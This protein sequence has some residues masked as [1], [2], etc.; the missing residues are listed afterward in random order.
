MKRFVAPVVLSALAFAPDA[1]AQTAKPTPAVQ[2]VVVVGQTQQ[3]QNRIDRTVYAVSRD[4]QATSG[5]AA[6]ILNN[7]PSVAVDPD[8]GL[9]LRGDSNVTVLVDGKPSAQFTGAAKGLSLQQ[10]PASQIERVEVLANPPAQ[11]KAE[12]SGGV[13]NIITKKT[14]KTGLSGSGQLTLGDKRRFV[15]ALEGAY[16]K[17]R[18]KLSGGIGLRQDSRQRLSTDDRVAVDP[19]TGV[20]TPSRQII[21]ERFRRLVP[22]IKAGVDYDLDAGQALGGSFSHREL[23]GVRFFDQND[24]VGPA[25]PTA[26]S[27]RHS[28]GHDWSSDESRALHFEQKLGRPGE[29]LSIGLQSS[30]SREQERYL[31]RNTFAVPSGPATFD[32]LHLAFAIRKD[33]FSADYVLP[34]ASGREL[35]LGYDLEDDHNDFD[36]N[37]NALTGPGGT[38]SRNTADNHF[39]YRQRINAVYGQYQA[40]LG[41]WRLQAGLRV[42]Q[43]DVAM[44][45]LV[46]HIPGGRRDVGVYPSLHLDRDIGDTAKLSASLS[47]RISRPDPEALNPFIDQ[48]NTHNLRAGNPNLLPQDTWSYQLGYSD[49]RGDLS[50]GATGYLR[51]DRNTVTDIVRPIGPDVVLATRA[52]LPNTRAGGIEFNLNGKIGPKLGYGLSGNLFLSQIDASGLGLRG[53]KS[54][55][56]LNLKASLDYRPTAA[57]SAQI[58]VSRADRRLT[59]QGYLDAVNLLNLGYRRQLRPDWAMVVTV[60]DAFAGQRQ[61]RLSVTASLTDDYVRRQDSQIVMAGLVYTFGAPKKG[62]GGGFE[63]EQ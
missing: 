23:K 44:L 21:D 8:G 37:A 42:E 56:G 61:R 40:P 25:T 63:Y 6:D 59:P 9:S 22:S 10:F 12:G 46:G 39:R 27:L 15:A 19:A 28:D 49:G 18:L 30:T 31:Y 11:F 55:T 51:F 33:E 58:S 4:L 17:D 2:E 53:L 45:Q 60:S 16:N 50:Y 24:R 52:N 48:Q 38:A 1:R 20:Q 41:P 57:D 35:K 32:D 7:I 29:T 3:T 43:A 14:G 13:I 54:T 62:K 36:D 34:L 5:T 26:S 47:R